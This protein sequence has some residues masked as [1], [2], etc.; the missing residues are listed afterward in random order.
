MRIWWA[1][2]SLRAWWAQL[3]VRA[4][5]V[6][7]AH[8]DPADVGVAVGLGTFIGCLPIFGLHLPVCVALSRRFRLNGALVYGAANISNPFF[9]P[10]LIAAEVAL[11]RWILGVHEEPPATET[12][13]RPIWTLIMDAPDLVLACSIGGAV[14]GAVLGVVFGLIGW[15][16]ALRWARRSLGKEAP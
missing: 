4:R 12:V 14:I 3:R 2:F 7:A 11:G 15:A 6:F 13:E 9:A 5:S 8:L 10:F 16:V 1:N